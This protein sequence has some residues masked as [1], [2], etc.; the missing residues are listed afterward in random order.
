VQLKSGPDRL[1]SIFFARERRQRRRSNVAISAGSVARSR[2]SSVYP[3]SPGMAILP[4]A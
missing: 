2:R 4:A 1:A 3:S